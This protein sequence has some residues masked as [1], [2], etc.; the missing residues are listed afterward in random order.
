GFGSNTAA[1]PFLWTNALQGPH[2]LMAVVDWGGGIT[3]TSAAV[4]ISVVSRPPSVQP[5]IATVIPAGSNWRYWDSLT[6][7]G[8]GWTRTDFIDSAW[9]LSPARFGWGLDGERT[10]LTEG[11]ITTYF[12][13]WFVF[14]NP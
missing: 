13:R 10:P 12:R 1:S 4:N 5:S 11:R 7:V 2:A 3:R 8:S 6:P 9:P 14:P